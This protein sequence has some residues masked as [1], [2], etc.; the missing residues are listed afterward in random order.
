M[1]AEFNAHTNGNHSPTRVVITG[2]G[3]VTPLGLTTA[4]T[5]ASLLAGR[6]GIDHIT[7]WDTSALGCTFAGEV[8]GFD[9]TDYM[10]RKEARRLDPFIQFALAATQQAVADAEID[11]S[12]MPTHRAG[13]IIGTAV[14]GIS[15]TMD[16]AKVA[17]VKGLNRIS[18]FLGTNMLVDSAAGKVAIEYNLRGPNHAVVSACASGT[19]AAARRLRF[20]AAAMRM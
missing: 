12:A 9:P 8:R 11:F 4:D 14:G 10:D 17:E 3:A 18:P 7:R 13:C 19:S 15:S 16:N 20:C 2:L 1:S 6:S 5:W